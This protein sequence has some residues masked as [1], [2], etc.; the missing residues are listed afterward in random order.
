M[1]SQKERRFLTTLPCASEVLE[2]I[3]RRHLASNN[4]APGPLQQLPHPLLVRSE[5][6]EERMLAR[7]GDIPAPANRYVTPLRFKLGGRPVLSG[8]LNLGVSRN[9]FC[10]FLADPDSRNFSRFYTNIERSR[11][12]HCSRSMNF[13]RSTPPEAALQKSKNAP[14][15][16]R[17]LWLSR[18]H[19]G[20]SSGF[21]TQVA[22]KWRNEN[23]KMACSLCLSRA[24]LGKI[25]HF[26]YK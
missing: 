19:L 3:D 7:L 18:A 21:S 10:D 22:I 13:L 23:A 20:K 4:R 26:I 1:A 25:M 11:Y 8:N 16:Q 9:R 15:F 14:L 12:M 17:F 5:R 24:C 6:V 2:Y